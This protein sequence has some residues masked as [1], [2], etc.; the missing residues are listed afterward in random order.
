MMRCSL[1]L[2]VAHNAEPSVRL[3]GRRGRSW[4]ASSRAMAGRTAATTSSQPESSRGRLPTAAAELCRPAAVSPPAREIRILAARSATFSP[5]SAAA[6]QAR[7]VEHAT[8]LRWRQRRP[9]D[10]TARLS[11]DRAAWLQSGPGGSRRRPEGSRRSRSSSTPD[12]RRS[13]AGT[14]SARPNMPTSWAR[15]RRAS[16]QVPLATGAPTAPAWERPV[17]SLQ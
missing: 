4:T 10:P 14:R 13:T 16:R 17:G 5:A 12:S 11:A 15:S 6:G 2:G 8:D 9:E 7:R 1:G 3:A